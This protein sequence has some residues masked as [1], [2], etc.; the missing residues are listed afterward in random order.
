MSISSYMGI[1]ILRDA[2]KGG[3]ETHVPYARARQ[4][5][6]C[7]VANVIEFPHR[8]APLELEVFLLIAA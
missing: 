3:P 5:E 1:C 8:M 4:Q 7:R 6:T 2:V